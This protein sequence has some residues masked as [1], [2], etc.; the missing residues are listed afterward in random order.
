MADIFGTST[1]DF[2]PPLSGGVG[3][4]RIFG[5]GGSDRLE[6]N[7]GND[8]LLGDSGND[9]LE[10]G[11]GNDL[12]EGGSGNDTLEGG[13]DND[14]YIVDS[15][16]DS[17]IEAA[18]A[19]I[20]LVR[21]SV[22]Y[23][24]TANVENLILQGPGIAPLGSPGINGTGNSLDNTITGDSRANI[25]NGLGGNDTLN[26]GGGND[27]LNV[28][29]SGNATLNGGTG[30]DIYIVTGISDTVNEAA[31]AGTDLV[32]SG[33]DFELLDDD[34]ENLTLTGTGNFDGT[35]NDGN[36]I[37][38]GNSGNNTLDGVT[39]NDIL[40]GGAG[41]DIY[42]VTGFSDTVT[43]GL[44]AGTDLVESTGS[45]TLSANVEDLTL[46]NIS[47]VNGTGNASNN[48]ITGNDGANVLSGLGGDDTLIGGLGNDTL[49]GGAGDDIL[50]S[51]GGNDFFEYETGVAFNTADVGVDAI[52]NFDSTG[53]TFDQ[54]VLDE[55]TFTALAG[56]GPSLTSFAQVANDSV[57]ATSMAFI[58]Y[59]LGSNGLF[60]N[61]NGSAAGFG[62]GGQ[63]A[64]LISSPSLQAADFLVQA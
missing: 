20:D 44:N 19:G 21:S 40:I 4:D 56:S 38:T 39:G 47:S 7:D 11:D 27:T 13:D 29:G 55:D 42:I 60:Y 35:G 30:N 49:N 1:S 23:T 31:S 57:A 9:T 53:A 41:D 3:D 46:T 64:E 18:G 45:F 5:F 43:E 54:I 15:S 12:L 10:G 25:L 14:T 33:S 51:G 22:S 36:N 26:G 32:Q 50:T 24:L 59:S 28:G 17:V 58:T 34:V 6:G 63:F 2:F 48:T 16:L 37:I 61:Q 52:T 8:L 62:T